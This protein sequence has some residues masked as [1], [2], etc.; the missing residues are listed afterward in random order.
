LLILA[1]A[2]KDIFHV[3]DGVI[4]HLPN[5]NCQSAQRDGVRA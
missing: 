2:A 1:Q 3:D 4:D 5:G